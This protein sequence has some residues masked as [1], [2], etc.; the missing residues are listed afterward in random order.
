MP[1]S[2]DDWLLEFVEHF[3]LPPL[4]PDNV[5]AVAWLSVQRGLSLSW[6]VAMRTLSPLS[7]V[8]L[9]A[10]AG[11]RR[12]DIPPPGLVEPVVLAGL[13]ISDRV[14]VLSAWQRLAKAKRKQEL[15]ASAIINFQKS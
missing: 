5:D 7:V 14:R 10:M 3:R 12:L 1:Y 8:L 9:S 2:L 4:V 6:S 13:P 15:A 11:A